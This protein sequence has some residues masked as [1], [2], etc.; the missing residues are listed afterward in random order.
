MFKAL[1]F[2][3]L[4]VTHFII[5][6]VELLVRDV[7]DKQRDEPYETCITLSLSR[8]VE[9]FDL[10]ESAMRLEREGYLLKPKFEKLGVG[11][12]KPSPSSEKTHQVDENP[13]IHTLGMHI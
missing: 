6:L 5:D 7:L 1:K 8:E 9:E 4:D 13:Y 10:Q 3:S 12:P 11:K 2:P